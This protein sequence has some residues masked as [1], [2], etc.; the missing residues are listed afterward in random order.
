MIPELFDPKYTYKQNNV[1]KSRVDNEYADYFQLTFFI[2]NERLKGEKSFWFP[3]INYL[4][5]DIQTLYSYPD[6]TSIY[7]GSTITLRDAV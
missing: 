2:I 7:E 5:E 4:P 3:F 6:N 1:V